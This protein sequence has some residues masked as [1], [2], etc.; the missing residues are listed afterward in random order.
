LDSLVSHAAE[1]LKSAERY[2]ATMM[3]K[4]C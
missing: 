4:V 1:E 3:D 2:L